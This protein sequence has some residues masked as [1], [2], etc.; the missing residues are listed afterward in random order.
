MN[1]FADSYPAGTYLVIR[2]Q[3][4]NKSLGDPQA[5]RRYMI[6]ELCAHFLKQ[7]ELNN[8]ND[9]LL[10]TFRSK[11][12]SNTIVLL[13][14]FH[15][16]NDVYCEELGRLGTDLTQF[17]NSCGI[18]LLI[19]ARSEDLPFDASQVQ[20]IDSQVLNNSIVVTFFFCL[21]MF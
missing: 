18:R 11:C 6:Q 12:N 19:T 20:I 16:F 1:R 9:E 15:D 17:R 2:C 7:D 5:I 4:W 8:S 3:S 10:K 13:D 21:M 14:G